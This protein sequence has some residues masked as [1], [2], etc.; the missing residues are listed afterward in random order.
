MCVYGVAG[1]GIEDREVSIGENGNW[2]FRVEGDEVRWRCLAVRN[3]TSTDLLDSRLVIDLGGC[4]YLYL[5][6]IFT[7][8]PGFAVYCLDRL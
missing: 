4:W 7:W 3:V 8:G 1:V 6:F 5:V 2:E